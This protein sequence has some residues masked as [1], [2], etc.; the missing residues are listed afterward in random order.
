MFK[1][2]PFSLFLQK[3]TLFY[4][5]FYY[6]IFFF[7]GLVPTVAQLSPDQPFGSIRSLAVSREVASFPLSRTPTP[8]PATFERLVDYILQKKYSKLKIAAPEKVADL[9]KILQ[10]CNNILNKN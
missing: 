6:Y 10:Y 5:L 8:P 2:N 7:R 9:N 4:V 3:K 1:R